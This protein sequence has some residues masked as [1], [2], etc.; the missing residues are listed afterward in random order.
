MTK[1][2]VVK[3]APEDCD[4]VGSTVDGPIQVLAPSPFTEPRYEFGRL[5]RIA[6]N[7]LQV[8][9]PR[10][11]RV[12][13]PHIGRIREID[14]ME[15]LYGRSIR[16]CSLARIDAVSDRVMFRSQ[17]HRSA[18]FRVTPVAGSLLS[19]VHRTRTRHRGVA[20]RRH[21]VGMCLEKAIGPSGTPVTVGSLSRAVIGRMTS[22]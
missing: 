20:E 17:T 10:G 22:L 16:K 5:I 3:S 14:P 21:A 13:R 18:S 4:E 7:D 2:R 9:G 8:A 15:D 1:M 11:D 12:A 6:S 19:G